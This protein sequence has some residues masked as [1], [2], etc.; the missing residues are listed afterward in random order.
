MTAALII[1]TAAATIAY[2]LARH[3]A[4][5]LAAQRDDLAAENDDLRGEVR[6]VR[7]ELR[8]A[9]RTIAAVVQHAEDRREQE[10]A[11]HADELAA[12]RKRKAARPRAVKSS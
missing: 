8:W 10:Q 2:L 9:R 1:A 12:A 11:A 6:E 4:A 3:R 5:D 7:A